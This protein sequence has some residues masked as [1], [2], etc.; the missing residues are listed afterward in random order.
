MVLTAQMSPMLISETLLPYSRSQSKSCPWLIDFFSYEVIMR[1][2]L[3]KEIELCKIQRGVVETVLLK[4]QPQ[5]GE[6]CCG[7]QAPGTEHQHN[8]DLLHRGEG[9]RPRQDD[10][11]EEYDKVRNRG[12]G[13][14]GNEAGLSVEALG[15][16]GWVPDT[17]YRQADD[18]L[19]D[20]DGDAECYLKGYRR[21]EKPGCFAKLLENTDE[22]EEQSQLG[23]EACNAVANGCCV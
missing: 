10:G 17:L 4:K 1:R 22:Q 23:R 20:G 18:D 12:H 11:R 16:H 19:D 21:P 13:R 2:L 9:E 8:P 15:R 3:P 14:V 6:A 7:G 5:P